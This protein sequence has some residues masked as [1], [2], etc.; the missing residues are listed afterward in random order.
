MKALRVKNVFSGT[1][2]IPVKK[3]ID[4]ASYDGK[5]IYVLSGWIF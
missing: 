1:E 4:I 2:C 3:A 5:I